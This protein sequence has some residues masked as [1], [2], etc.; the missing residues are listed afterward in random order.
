MLAARSLRLRPAPGPLL[1]LARSR[2]KVEARYGADAAATEE[3]LRRRGARE[4]GGHRG[5]KLPATDDADPADFEA[6]GALA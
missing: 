3:P 1:R 5:H 2:A 6:G 4:G